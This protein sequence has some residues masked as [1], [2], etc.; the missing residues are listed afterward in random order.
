METNL[1]TKK[2][3]NAFRSIK[4]LSIMYSI[5]IVSATIVFANRPNPYIRPNIYFVLL[6]IA[7]LTSFVEIIIIYKYEKVTIF[8]KILIAVQLILISIHY[9]IT[10]T[11]MFH[12]PMSYDPWGHNYLE[13][14]ITNIGKLPLSWNSRFEF[15]QWPLRDIIPYTKMPNFHIFHVII[16]KMSG[17]TCLTV[18]KITGVITLILIAIIV[19][20]ISDKVL[21]IRNIGL[22]AL[23]FVVISDNVLYMTGIN[24]VPNTIGIIFVLIIYYFIGIKE[25]MRSYKRILTNIV[26]AI[27]LVLTHSLSMALLIIQVSILVILRY[28]HACV[29]K[30]DIENHKNYDKNYRNLSLYLTFL[31]ALALFQW[32]IISGIYLEKALSMVKTLFIYGPF[33]TNTYLSRVGVPLN[34]VLLARSG[35]LIY[36]LIVLISSMRVIVSSIMRFNSNTHQFAKSNK[37]LIEYSIITIFFTGIGLVSFILPKFNEIALR[38]WYYSEILGGLII[39]NEIHKHIRHVQKKKVSFSK[40]ITVI[41]LLLFMVLLIAF[42]FIKSPMA[43]IDNSLVPEYTLRRGLYD[44]EVIALKFYS[45]YGTTYVLSDR[46]YI[47]RLAYFGVPTTRLKYAFSEKE[48]VINDYTTL[49]RGYAISNTY[50]LLGNRWRRWGTVLSQKDIKLLYNIGYSERSCIY[51]SKFIRIFR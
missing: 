29:T 10:Q 46:Y 39:A 36:F 17:L 21:N 33:D 45:N 30:Y 22:M 8:N 35:M 41:V 15:S 19:A 43:N 1:Q 7:F 50:I 28:A 51:S 11:T 24:V 26:L 14:Y 42:L 16:S 34:V 2:C 37:N 44:S 9:S 12:V 31:V 3:N 4:L 5:L 48:L 18:S 13:Q 23:S 6:L 38:Y 25:D 27:S 32:G 47:S 40:Y 49:F 20:I